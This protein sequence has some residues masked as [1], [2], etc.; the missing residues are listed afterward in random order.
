MTTDETPLEQSERHIRL[1][2]DAI[3]RQEALIERL[4][5]RGDRRDA[6]LARNVLETMRGALAA[7]MQHRKIQRK[8]Y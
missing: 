1:M 4:D 3:A 2:E 6:T 7:G 5:Q 8:I